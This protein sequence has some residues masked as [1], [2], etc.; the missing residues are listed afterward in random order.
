MSSHKVS[1]HARILRGDTKEIEQ[2]G[3]YHFVLFIPLV[4]RLPIS[5]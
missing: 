2:Y 5:D 4:L 1:K 3:K